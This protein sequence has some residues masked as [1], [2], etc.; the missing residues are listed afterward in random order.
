[1]DLTNEQLGERIRERRERRGLSQ[2]ELGARL[3]VDQS[4]VSRLEDGSRGITARELLAISDSLGV[5]LNQ[6]VEA[7]SE[8]PALLR[9]GEA[10]GD[11]VAESLRIFGECIDQFR[12]VQALAG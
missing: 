9:A 7:G 11:A 8:A 10:D 12:G 3:G 2:T 6:L 4:V 5:A 1:M